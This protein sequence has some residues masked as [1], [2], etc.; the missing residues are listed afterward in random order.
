MIN[1]L[2]KVNFKF[3]L[4]SGTDSCDWN[5]FHYSMYFM[6]VKGGQYKVK[7]SSQIKNRLRALA[8]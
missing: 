7:T 4:A 3:Y 6:S 1:N 2:I 8:G 5:I